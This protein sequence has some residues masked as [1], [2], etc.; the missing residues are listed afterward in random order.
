M[1]YK[2]VIMRLMQNVS[3]KKLIFIYFTIYGFSQGAGQRDYVQ[4]SSF[5]FLFEF[6]D[7]GN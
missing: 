6:E 5:Y 3:K 1:P 7:D 4:K 2:W